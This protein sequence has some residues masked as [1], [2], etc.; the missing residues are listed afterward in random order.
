MRPAQYNP[1]AV[2]ALLRQRK[3]ATM[4]ELKAAL[5][6]NADATVFRKLA[7]LSYRTSYS[8][9][10]QY[11]TLDELARFDELGL[12][13]F[14]QVWFSRF[15]TL[16]A[17]AEALVV[18]SQAGFGA[19]E[20]E[21]VLHVEAKQALLHL[22]RAG[23]ITREQ[24]AGRYVYLSPQSATR[25]AL[26]RTRSVY[27]AEASALLLGPG[28]RVLPEELKGCD[29]AVLQP[30]GRAP[31]APVRR[32]RGDEDR[33]RRRRPGLSAARHRP[34]HGGTRTA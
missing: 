14:R 30:V 5:G 19:S 11:Y 29:R 10:G 3:I 20:L 21:A 24:V 6:T 16:V 18:G 25:R 9:R 8:H 15:G 12:W 28:L 2:I 34:G 32:A 33:P 13:S 22:V 1:E 17:T 7:D 27:D 26:L 4:E 31:A 23:R